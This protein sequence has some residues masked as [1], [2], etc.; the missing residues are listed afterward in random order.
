MTITPYTPDEQ[1]VADTASVTFDGS[2]SSTGQALI[3]TGSGNFACDVHI[4]RSSDGGSA[5]TEVA[6]IDQPTDNWNFQGDRIFVIENV[7]RLKFTN[8]SGS[9]G[10]LE[11]AGDEI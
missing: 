9:S 5:W 3:T 8:T 11:V 1:S 10:T 7:R 4:E 6:L 2:T